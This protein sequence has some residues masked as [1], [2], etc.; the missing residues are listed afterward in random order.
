MA[1][2]PAVEPMET[3]PA[4]PAGEV[5]LD[6][7]IDVDALMGEL[8]ALGKTTP[9]SIK[10]MHEASQQS[11]N[12]ANLVGD[13]RAEI[14]NLKASKG[15][16]QPSQDDYNDPSSV[17]LGH[18]IDSRLKVGLKAGLEEF[19]SEKQENQSKAYQN[20][21]ADLS[22][23][24][25]DKYYSRIKDVYDEH[26]KAPDIQVAINNGQTSYSREY[27]RVKDKYV[28]KLLEQSGRTIEQLTSKGVKPSPPHL[29]SGSPS[30][31]APPETG[32]RKDKIKKIVD[33]STGSDGDLDK[34]LDVLLPK[35]DPI[36]NSE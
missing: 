16:P 23:V 19:W 24:R 13:L 10:G 15:Q 29:E 3:P 18:L 22:S 20:M 35:G 14:D 34:M 7:E 8:K 21:M 33:T 12:Y 5:K 11:G 2:E 9:E 28:D 30:V 25:S 4:E 26:L 36:F 17:D 27:L 32:E 31:P 6:D 1:E